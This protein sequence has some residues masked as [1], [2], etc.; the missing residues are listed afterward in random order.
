MPGFDPVAD[1]RSSPRPGPA[2]SRAPSH[3]RQ[4]AGRAGQ[5]A[6]C[7]AARSSAATGVGK[8]IDTVATAI[9]AGLTADDVIDLDLAYAPPFSPVWD[10]V[11]IAARQRRPH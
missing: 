2:T 11:D 1:H 5:P 3:R 7:S 6:G 8:R 10:P 9:W 4:A